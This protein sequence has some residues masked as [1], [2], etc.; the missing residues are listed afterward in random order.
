MLE[1]VRSHVDDRQTPIQIEWLREDMVRFKSTTAILD[2]LRSLKTTVPQ[3]SV[4]P[5]AIPMNIYHCFI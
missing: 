1:G 5:T 2:D 3:S 4:N